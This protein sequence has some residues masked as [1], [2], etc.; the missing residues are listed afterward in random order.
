MA[1]VPDPAGVDAGRDPAGVVAGWADAV[2]YAA[3]WARAVRRLGFVPLSLAET[4][5]LLLAHTVRL[6]QAIR[7]EPF[8]VGPA[9][10]VGR[11]L[12]EAHL[13][14]PQALEWTLHALGATFGRRVLSDGERPADLADRIAAMQGGLAAGFA[15]ALRDRTFS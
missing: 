9:E 12:V 1:A 6:A 14:E 4:E 5:R 13:T 11:A 3:D 8:S 10:E 2:G 15:R 7:A